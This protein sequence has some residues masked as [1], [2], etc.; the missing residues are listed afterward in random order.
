M[1]ETDQR[2]AISTMEDA[3]EYLE[4]AVHEDH[5]EMTAR[6]G[7]ICRCGLDSIR[8]KLDEAIERLKGDA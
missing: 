8:D 5:C 4:S 7:W 3:K 2:I 6:N 1:N